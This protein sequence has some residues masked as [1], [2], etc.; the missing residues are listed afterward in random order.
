MTLTITYDGTDY[1]F[2]Y[3]Q[4]IREVSLTLNINSSYLLQ[5]IVLL[6]GGEAQVALLARAELGRLLV[7]L[8]LP[9]LDLPDLVL[10]E[11]LQRHD[12]VVVGAL[13]HPVPLVLE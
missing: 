2:D 3:C 11:R 6:L 8:L 12:E 5:H 7:E 4:N 1:S 9:L 10:A 13:Q